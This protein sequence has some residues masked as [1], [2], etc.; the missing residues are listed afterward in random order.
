MRRLQRVALQRATEDFAGIGVNPSAASGAALL[1]GSPP[2]TSILVTA[3]LHTRLSRG[4]SL[5]ARTRVHE[6][7]LEGLEHLLCC[8]LKLPL[9]LERLT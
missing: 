6:R 8:A 5:Q 1:P 7:G 4:V 9:S 2:A 3:H